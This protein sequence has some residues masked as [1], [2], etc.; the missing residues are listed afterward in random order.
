MTTDSIDWKNPLEFNAPKDEKN[1]A[2]NNYGLVLN[3]YGEVEEQYPYLTT[4]F[5]IAYSMV[6]VLSLVGNSLILVVLLRRK[7]MRRT[8]T[9][10]F[11]ANITIA[12]LVYTICAPLQFFVH[13]HHITLPWGTACTLLPFASTLAINV[14]TFSMMAASI[15]RFV[16][17][18]YPFVAKLKKRK[19]G[20]IIAAIW[21]VSIVVSLPWFLLVR[22]K[23]VRSKYVTPQIFS[24][25]YITLCFSKSN[26]I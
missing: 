16:A 6:T 26:L 10:F 18:V 12:N 9:N 7:R 20:F 21:I 11:L 23:P 5:T 3:K 17:I 1:E 24:L 25:V 22:A 15:E 14:N 8:V 19:C 2:A 4:A 13:A